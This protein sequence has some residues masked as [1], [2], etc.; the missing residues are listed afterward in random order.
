MHTDLT[1]RRQTRRRLQLAGLTAAALILALAAPL[2]ALSQA[3]AGSAPGANDLRALI[4]Y[5][6]HNDQRAVQAEM[7]RLRAQYPGWTPPTDL[8]QL[9]AQATTTAPA[10]DVAPIWSR[11]E[12]GDFTAARSLIDQARSQAP[13]WTPDAE[14]LRQ[15]DLGEGQAAFDAGYAARDPARVIAAARRTPAIMRCDRINNAWRLAEMYQTA[16][17]RETA[18]ETYRG[19]AGAC[20]RQ[21][22]A[23]ATMEK[24]NEIATWPEMEQL[25][26]TAR[27]AGAGNRS[28]L[29]QL[30]IR[31]AAGRGQGAAPAAGAAARVSGA[32]GATAATRPAPPAAPAAPAA[33]PVVAGGGTP[34]A[35]VPLAAAPLAAVADPGSLPLRGDSRLAAVRQLKERGRWA[36]CVAA[37][38]APGSVE[39]LYE[40][41]WCVYNLNR[42]G[43]A[44]TGFAAT[45]RT[46]AALGGTVNRD[47]RFGMTLAYLALN[48]TE[49]G[50]GVAAATDLTAQQRREVEATILDQRGVRAYQGRDYDGAIR[51]FDALEQLTGTLRRDLAM[52][53][54]YA[55]MNTNRDDQA[56]DQFARLH[57]QLATDDTR[58][59]LRAI[60][61]RRGG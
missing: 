24:A 47:A 28:A 27:R 32:T 11:I 7:R 15:L 54:G 2:P 51:Y 53:R 4:Y 44:L 29:D 57:A 49:A 13:G 56:H 16:G 61:G 3:A 33:A 9:R 41:S 21:S 14:M 34:L 37:S 5:L 20:T 40:R 36:E 59:A 23:L 31:L 12:R 8:G 38:T 25:F 18:V 55:Y 35:A 17:Q 1:L 22:D 19:V 52:M 58:A 26:E 60:A 45:E 43:E 42:P 50:A 6:D 46:G 30:Q 10:V 48:M 39:L